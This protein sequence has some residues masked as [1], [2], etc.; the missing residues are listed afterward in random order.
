MR[1]GR[2]D[3]LSTTIVENCL[4]DSQFLSV[5]GQQRKESVSTIASERASDCVDGIAC[6]TELE[7][8]REP[9][10]VRSAFQASASSAQ[11]LSTMR[12]P[13]ISNETESVCASSIGR[14]DSDRHVVLQEPAQINAC[15]RCLRNC[16]GMLRPVGSDAG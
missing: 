8:A 5:N 12:S 15:V 10:D 4:A 16:L 7:S 6:A 13:L 1:R 2:K 9:G 11:S 14:F 3:L